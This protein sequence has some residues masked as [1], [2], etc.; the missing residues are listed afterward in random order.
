MIWGLFIV[1]VRVLND[2]VL[3]VMNMWC[4]GGLVW[5]GMLR[6]AARRVFGC[7]VGYNVIECFV[8]M[9]LC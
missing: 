7:A 5:G 9:V 1:C 3:M 2:V 8:V 4:D 6:A